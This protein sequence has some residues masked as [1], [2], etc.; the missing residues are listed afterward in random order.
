MSKRGIIPVGLAIIG[1]VVLSSMLIIVADN[2]QHKDISGYA[3][4]RECQNVEKHYIRD[5]DRHNCSINESTKKCIEIK[6]RYDREYAKK[7]N[8]ASTAA[9]S[10]LSGSASADDDNGNN[11]K[12]ESSDLNSFDYDKLTGSYLKW[13][14]TSP[15][16]EQYVGQDYKILYNV[17]KCIDNGCVI[18]QGFDITACSEC[19][20]SSIVDGWTF[21]IY[22]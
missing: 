6:E 20:D 19:A 8:A 3:S 7:C 15:G 2:V 21:E 1:I 16:Y 10:I 22:K 18:L 17:P 12:V 11:D 4:L 13:T 9:Q 5:Y 14:G